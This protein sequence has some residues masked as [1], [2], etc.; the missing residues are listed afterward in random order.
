MDRRLYFLIPDRQHALVVVDEL[1]EQ[2]IDLKHM[3]ALGDKRT[4]LDG[5]PNATLRQKNDTA[6]RVE[7][8]FWNTNL[9]SFALALIALI[10]LPVLYGLSGWLL[11]P[12]SIMLIN[13]MMG[14]H[15]TNVP[16]THLGEFRDALA[17]GE[18]LLMVDVP[19]SRVAEVETD[20]QHHHPEATV[21]GVGW[22]SQAFGL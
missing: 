12:V 6:Q 16:N 21:G 13:F 15:F 4:R 5:L 9:A 10:V 17:H 20:I 8:I 11:I 7:K 2:G 18:I 22:G 3:H 1:A 19:E 14:L